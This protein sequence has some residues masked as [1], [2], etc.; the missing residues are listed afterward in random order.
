MK[1]L[2]FAGLAGVLAMAPSGAYAAIDSVTD[3]VAIPLVDVSFAFSTALAG[4]AEGAKSMPRMG[5]TRPMK[6]MGNMRHMKNMSGRH[7]MKNMGHTRQI[8]HMGSS[9]HMKGRHQAG[10]FV[11]QGRRG[12]DQGYR[13]PHRGFRLPQTYVQPSYFIGNFGYYGLS[14]PNYGYGWS[15][16]YDD[17]VLT[18]RQGVVQDARYNVDWDRY[19]QG[20]QDGYRA[21]QATYDPSVFTGDDRVVSTPSAYNS[22]RST[23]QGDWQG[24]YQQD[25]SYQGDWQGTYRDAEGR[26]YEGEYSGTFIGDGNMNPHWG[27][28]QGQAAGSDRYVPYP[29][30]RAFDSARAEEL[31]YVERCKKSSGIGGAIVG[32][33]IGAVAG[34]RIAGRGNRLGGSLIGGGLGAVAGAAIDQGTDRCRKLLDKY[35][36][37]QQ[38]SGHYPNHPPVRHHSQQ[39]PQVYPAYP[40]GWNGQYGPAY[41]Y[42]QA[43]PMVTTI[44]IQSAP[45]TTTTTTTYIEEEV[46]Y[47]KPTYKK[48][49]KPA[50]KK[51]WKPAPKAAPLKGCQQAR[52][53]YD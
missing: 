52:C 37:D 14:Q 5:N 17:A 28:Q 26:V 6:S 16:Y 24:A 29:D 8:K 10:N 25:G 43:Q 12:Y 32:G 7:K 40:S 27:S 33:A 44:V 38:H 30:D 49:W 18:D 13:K 42:P 2:I 35:G 53:M 15:R 41:Y 9:R 21:G 4:P 45:V 50:S 34:N 19:N 11:R 3:D 51:T 22:D 39:Q 48:R 20:Y 46:V 47:S 31:A 1:T 23:Y 36:Y